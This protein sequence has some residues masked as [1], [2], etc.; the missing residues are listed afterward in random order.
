[1]ETGR[2]DTAAPDEWKAGM[3]V[4]TADLRTKIPDFRGFD[5]II[6]LTV[7]GGILTSIGD[8]P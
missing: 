3:F 1:M 5:S 7:R 6:I 8:L 4:V 2:D